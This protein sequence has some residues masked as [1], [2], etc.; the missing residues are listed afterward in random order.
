MLYELFNIK[1]GLSHGLINDVILQIQYKY[2]ELKWI[3]LKDITCILD[4]WF[5]YERIYEY[6]TIEY[7][8]VYSDPITKVNKDT[9]GFTIK[10]SKKYN[11][12]IFNRIKSRLTTNTCFYSV[13][14]GKNRIILCYK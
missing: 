10:P 7:G 8:L 3:K 11:E 1:Q 4:K 14:S 5:K 9:Y 12:R 13:K 2:Y 6:I